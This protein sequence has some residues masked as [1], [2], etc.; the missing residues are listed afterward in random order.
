VRNS[1]QSVAECDEPV[2]HPA[3]AAA[4]CTDDPAA[5]GG[6]TTTELDADFGVVAEY[7]SLAGTLDNRAGGI[8]PWRSSSLGSR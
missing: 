8:T 4:E 2:D 3:I 6:T 1:E 7:V 5:L